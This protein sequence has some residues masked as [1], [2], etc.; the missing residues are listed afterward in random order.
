MTEVE[1]PS[2]TK[3]SDQHKHQEEPYS[4]DKDIVVP[5][6]TASDAADDGTEYDPESVSHI[7]HPPA[8]AAP[9]MNQ[10]KASKTASGFVVDS[11]DEE[12]AA[13][14][15]GLPAQPAPGPGVPSGATGPDVSGTPAQHSVIAGPPPEMNNASVSSGTPIPASGRAPTPIPSFELDFVAV[16]EQRVKNDPL[17]DLDAWLDLMKE[18]R[19]R[20]RF[21]ELRTV[22]SRF[23]KIFP[24]SVSDRRPLF[25]CLPPH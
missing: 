16:L 4:V 23:L 7:L 5:G 12:D 17:G 9:P 11:S 8:P 18:H 24:H 21:D 10:P 13:R 15:A 6:D 19:Q 20:N 2:L 14:H 3:D 1:Q 25:S 22:Y